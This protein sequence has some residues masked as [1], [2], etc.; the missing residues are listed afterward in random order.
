M[1]VLVVDNYDSFTYNLCDLIAQVFQTAPVVVSNDVPWSTVAGRHFDAAVISP[2]PG[3]PARAGD[4][5]ISRFVISE[6]NVPTL[7]VCLGHQGIC[8]LGGGRIIS[9]P[10]PMHGRLSRIYHDRSP[11]FRH[12]PNPFTAVRY[13]SFVCADPLPAHLARLAWTEDDLV[14]AIADRSKPVWGVQFHPES[15]STACGRQLI[16]NFRDLSASQ[17]TPSAVSPLSPGPRRSVSGRSEGLIV[18]RS[19]LHIEPDALFEALF[20]SASYAFWLDSSSLSATDARFSFMGGF[21]DNEAEFVRYFVGERRIETCR[22][23]ETE[24]T[25]GDLFEYLKTRLSDAP[26]DSGDLPFDFTA[27]FI[28]YFGYE[29]RALGGCPGPHVSGH[30]D[31]YLLDVDRFVAIDHEDRSS[32]MVCRARPEEAAEWFLSLEE[33][34][35][36]KGRSGSADTDGPAVPETSLEPVV[37]RERYLE[38]I[39][40]C[41]AALADGESYEICLSNRL[42]SQTSVDP[43]QFYLRLRRQNPAPYSAFL[44]FPGLQIACSSPERFLKISPDGSVESRP[45]KG[46][47]RRGSTRAED[48]LLRSRL[49]EDEKSRAE[50]L[51]IVDLLRNDLSRVCEVGSVSVPRMMAVETLPTLHQLVSSVTGKLRSDQTAVDCLRAA[52]PGGSMTGAPKRRTMAI[53]DALE[54]EARGVY[55]G[56]IG[57]LSRN[58][59]ADLNIVIRTAVFGESVVT[60][61][62]GGAII[63]LSDPA[64]EWEEILLKAEA[65]VGTFALCARQRP[66]RLSLPEIPD[67]AEPIR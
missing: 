5:G 40:Q 25:N 42:R 51:M 36:G 54:E 34:L 47:V 24:S 58:G 50:N 27:G 49:A 19:P 12:I 22:K 62:V 16:E 18:R 6:M 17:R 39:R 26:T 43:L 55:S 7:G 28:G 65:V 67:C 56:S 63:A 60:V 3:H 59:A 15:V 61:G 41:L 37:S 57:F 21:S 20:G 46:T 4:F 31:S 33:R 32:Y 38:C 30:P 45:I 64:E 66:L 2:G 13:H 1:T 53:I 10:L 48:E 52:F 23:G 35:T 11:L 44:R 14:M 29:L 9:A 8:H